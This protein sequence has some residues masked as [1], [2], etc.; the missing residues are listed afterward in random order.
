[1]RAIEAG[2]RSS[3]AIQASNMDAAN[4]LDRLDSVR[5]GSA[6]TGSVADD[7]LHKQSNKSKHIAQV[8]TA[9][10]TE[11]GVPAIASSPFNQQEFK[12]P[13]MNTF[14]TKMPEE[15][16]YEIPLKDGKIDF[17]VAMEDIMK[18]LHN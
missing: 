3:D 5:L 18:E 4:L 12:Q 10:G 14:L 8:S 17:D 9:Q 11:R 2:P 7:G 15:D 6:E 13:Q 16:Q 1:M